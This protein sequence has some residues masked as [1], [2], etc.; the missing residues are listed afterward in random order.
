MERGIAEEEERVRGGGVTEGGVSEL[1]FG[2]GAACENEEGEGR[3]GEGGQRERGRGSGWWME[4]AK[5]L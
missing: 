2:D 1:Q 3:G 4:M 5:D